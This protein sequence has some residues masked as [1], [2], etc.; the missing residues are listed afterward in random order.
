MLLFVVQLL[1]V[2]SLQFTDPRR[3]NTSRYYVE[4]DV[5]R[6]ETRGDITK[7]EFTKLSLCLSNYEDF[8]IIIFFI[9]IFSFPGLPLRGYIP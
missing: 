5:L 8:S 3:W 4:P 1:R 7:G 2:E 6:R 9:F